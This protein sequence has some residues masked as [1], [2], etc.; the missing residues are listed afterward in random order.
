MAALTRS[1]AV[2]MERWTHHQFILASGN[3]AWKGA[4]AVGDQTTGKVEP[5][6]G[7]EADLLSLGHF[8]EDVDAS[9]GD[10]AVT[11]DLG[12]EIEVRWQE[13]D[14]SITA[15]DVFKL[16]YWADDQTVTATATGNSVAG[17]IW[18]VD[19]TRGVAIQLLR[20]AGI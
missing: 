1:R 7:G 11:V 15:A 20:F 14:G 10:R 12:M 3:K 2:S 17:R 13:N 4:A 19:S 16:A 8:D 5:A 6:H 9:T 18:A